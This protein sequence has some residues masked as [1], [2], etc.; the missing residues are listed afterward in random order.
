VQGNILSLGPS[1]EFAMAKSAVQAVI[2]PNANAYL[3]SQSGT[4]HL[5]IPTFCHLGSINKGASSPWK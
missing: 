4:S 1:E 3:C 5:T 2:S